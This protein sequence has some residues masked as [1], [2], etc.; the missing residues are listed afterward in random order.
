MA[1]SCRLTGTERVS[2]G[3]CL[4]RTSSQPC[5]WAKCFDKREKMIKNRNEKVFLGFSSCWPETASCFEN[6]KKKKPLAFRWASCL[7]HDCVFLHSCPAEHTPLPHLH[8]LQSSVFNG[9]M[10]TY[11]LDALQIQP[12]NQAPWVESKTGHSAIKLCKM[13]MK[14]TEN[15]FKTFDWRGPAWC[16]Q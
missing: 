13:R 10:N 16:L 1:R 3:K 6:S 7:S 15:E 4:R 12:S 11:L 14:S 9:Y 2:L 5:N 8:L